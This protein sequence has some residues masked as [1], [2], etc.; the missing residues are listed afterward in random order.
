MIRYDLQQQKKIQSDIRKEKLDECE[1]IK[2]QFI[3]KL[4]D[5][6]KIN[7]KQQSEL[8]FKVKP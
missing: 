7:K 4:S 5:L 6:E 8:E 3:V 1:K 2:K